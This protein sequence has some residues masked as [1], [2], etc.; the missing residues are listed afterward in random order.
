M[1]GEEKEEIRWIHTQK[2]FGEGHFDHRLSQSQLTDHRKR[3]TDLQFGKKQ[4]AN[5]RSVVSIGIYF[6]FRYQNQ[7]WERNSQLGASLK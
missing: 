6:E 7:Y 2:C 1:V 5:I 3:F 4:S